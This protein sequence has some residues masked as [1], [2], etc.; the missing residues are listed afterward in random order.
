MEA[1]LIHHVS[2]LHITV[3]IIQGIAEI[4]FETQDDT[5]T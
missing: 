3:T 5:D 1:C 4:I 2:G